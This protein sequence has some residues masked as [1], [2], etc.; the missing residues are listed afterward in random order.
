MNGLISFERTIE[1]TAETLP[2]AAKKQNNLQAYVSSELS[3]LRTFGASGQQTQIA[4]PLIR[5]QRRPCLWE[6]SDYPPHHPGY[7]APPHHNPQE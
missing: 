5:I 2:L 3:L 4:P 1:Q 6:S 7:S